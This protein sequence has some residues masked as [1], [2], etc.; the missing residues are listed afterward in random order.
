[1]RYVPRIAVALLIFFASGEI[2]A[3]ALDIVDRL[4]G[5]NRL[6]YTRGPTADLPYLLRPGLDVTLFGVPVH[7]NRLGIRDHEIDVGPRAGVHRVLMLGDSVLFWTVLRAEDR[8]SDRL[9]HALDVAR[10]GVYEVVNAGVPGFNTRAELVY[11]ERV[12]LALAPATVVVAFSL[13]DYED[14]PHMSPVGVLSRGDPRYGAGIVERSEFLLLLRWMVAYRRG[15]LWHQFVDK[16]ETGLEH[17][18]PNAGNAEAQLDRWVTAR[19]LAFYRNPDGPELARLRTALRDL[20]ARPVAHGIRLLV[21]IFPESYQIGANPDLAP[22]RLVLAEC[23]AAEIRCLD[24]QAAFATARGAL[25][26]DTQHPNARGHAIAA[27][28][29]ARELLAGDR[30]LHAA[31]RRAM[32]AAPWRSIARR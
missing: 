31:P 10:P 22:Q 4:N 3:R 32:K 27:T 11:L 1:M 25:F 12:G 15:T 5:Y 29:I 6:L 13:N 2:L 7:V 24:L 16:A 30:E 18:V 17:P 9:Q 14:V 26:S 28:E 8:V 23:A 19:H 20:H 21:A